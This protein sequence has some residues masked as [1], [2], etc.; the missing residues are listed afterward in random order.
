MKILFRILSIWFI[1]LT[2]LSYSCKKEDAIPSIL[3]HPVSIIARTS[4]WLKGTI[5]PGSA[6]SVIE[7]G[8]CW[9]TETL[10]TLSDQHRITNHRDSNNDL[11]LYI[12][13]LL[14]G[15]TYYVRTYAKTMNGTFYG[16]MVSFTTKPPTGSINFNA[17]LTY[18]TVSD[19]DGNIYKTIQI[20]QQVWMAENLKT[21]RFNDGSSIPLVEDENSWDI[22]QTPGYCWFENNEAVFRN[23]YGAYYNW[24]TVNTGL[25]CPTGW[26]I[27]NEEDWKVLKIS[28]GM[29]EE[30]ADQILG[31]AGTTEGDKIR[32]KGVLNWVEESRE[33]NNESG[34]TALPGGCRSVG[35]ADFLWE[36]TDASWWSATSAGISVAWS[37]GVGYN[38]S[39]IWRSDMYVKEY[40]QNI[41]CVK[42]NK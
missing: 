7:D 30:Q 29:T 32:E 23:I 21:T 38:D 1:F 24:Y 28:L 15:T 31:V 37:H 3:T 42:D 11:V 4:A 5:L 36:G 2:V 8:F 35:S 6:D 39:G 40:G 17:L 18:G 16:N 10:P 12:H 41:R 27:P 25:L 19:I 20:E 34:F 33:A 9:S 13:G 22:L 14:S 26:H